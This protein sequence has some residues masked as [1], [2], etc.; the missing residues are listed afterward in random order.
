MRLRELKEAGSL[1][2]K[3][4]LLRAELNVPVESGRVLDLFRLRAALPT[5][6][7]LVKAGA[8]TT[9]VAHLG[10]KGESLMHLADILRRELPLTFIRDVVGEEAK[11][12]AAAL[13]PG[14]VLL[15]EDVRTM[16][17]EEENSESFAKELASFGDCFVNDA[18]SVSHRAHASIVGVPKFLPSYAGLQL[19]KE[20]AELGNALKPKSP[21]LCIIGGAKFETKGPLI[22][23]FLDDYDQIFIGGAIANDVFR[24]QGLSVG[25]SLVSKEH[26]D[27]SSLTKHPKI[28]LPVDVVVSGTKVSIK[29]P[30]EIAA[31]ECVNDVGPQTIVEVA[32]VIRKASFI[33]WNGPMGNY[34]HGFNTQ[35]ESLARTIALSGAYS[36]VGGG[37][38]VAAIAK[39]ELEDRFSFV[40]TG[41][42][43]MLEFLEKGTL[44][45]LEP[46]KLP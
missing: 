15:L 44:P 9:V 32:K 6:H 2:N 30:T 37:D 34:E 16:P 27:F 24:A 3:R 14:Q 17:G 45:G 23:K 13:S 39:L 11:A 41:G 42:G 40:S 22:E 7:E 29:K 19:V 25:T 28:I 10:R 43:A 18:F 31:H 4:V 8:R 38:T 36:V 1:Q 33:L 21:S 5:L 20:V 26:Y 35:T 12:A 46:L